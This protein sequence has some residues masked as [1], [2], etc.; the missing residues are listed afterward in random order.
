MRSPRRRLHPL[1][2]AVHAPPPAS[3]SHLQNQ[4]MG[5]PGAR[6]GVGMGANKGAV[7]VE[8]H[9]THTC[10]ANITTKTQDISAPQRFP[11]APLGW[12]PSSPAPQYD[13]PQQTSQGGFFPPS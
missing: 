12:L 1:G 11:T 13:F 9:G 10:M 8:G 4:R 3:R 5:I 2:M 7:G 6:C